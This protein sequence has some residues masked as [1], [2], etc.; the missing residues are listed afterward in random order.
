MVRW[1][2]HVGLLAKAQG[3]VARSALKLLQLQDK[4]RIIQQGDRILDLGCS[5]GAWL[6]VAC[7]LLG[8]AKNGGRVMGIDIKETALPLSGCDE[9]VEAIK[10]DVRDLTAEDLDF[11]CPGG[12]EVVLS[13]MCHNTT[14]NA[15]L[16]GARSLELGQMAAE[17]ALGRELNDDRT[18]VTSSGSL[19][20]AEQQVPAGCLR[21]H[22]NLVIKLL[23]GS[24]SE[25]FAK[26]LQPHFKKVAWMQ[27]EASRRASREMY[28]L[29][30]RRRRFL[31]P[32]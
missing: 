20:H 30:L 13:D 12:F 31:Q 3:Y 16:D 32:G 2:D 10:A 26:Q 17:V 21:Q 18:D 19:S 11:L 6:Q 9:R 14:G 25:L 4:H 5:P 24:G 15:M 27:P 8:D 7:K 1:Q 29:G 22:G 28:L 23:Q